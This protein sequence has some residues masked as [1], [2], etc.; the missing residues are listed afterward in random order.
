VVKK[1]FGY[2]FSVLKKLPKNGKKLLMFL[3][4]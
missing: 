4:P 1:H 2:F 3:K